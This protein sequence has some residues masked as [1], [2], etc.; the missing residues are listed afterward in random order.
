[1]HCAAGNCV[2]IALFPKDADNVL[3]LE[4]VLLSLE[5]ESGDNVVNTLQAQPASIVLDL[6]SVVLYE[7]RDDYLPVGILSTL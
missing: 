4:N 2:D 7:I 6:L 3:D 5:I 1:M